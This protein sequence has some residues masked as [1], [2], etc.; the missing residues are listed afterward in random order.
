MD[1]G[2]NL[3][4]SRRLDDLLFRIRRRF[5]ALP[6]FG[7]AAPGPCAPSASTLDALAAVRVLVVEDE[8]LHQLITREHLASFGI[9][10]LL[11][12]DGAE[13]V[14]RACDTPFDLILMD[15]QMPV[16][17]GLT[18][19]RQIRRFEQEHARPRVPV[20]AHS[21]CA[22]NSNESF[23]RD[24]GIDAVLEKPCSTNVLRE[25]LMRWCPT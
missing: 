10:P 23:L 15:L 21:S 8:P 7:A 5:A 18:A 9:T 24:F 2:H 17:D 14:A 6:A 4:P 16:L 3:S 19:T 22:Y 20:I 12:V 13:A 25:C 1:H 11:A